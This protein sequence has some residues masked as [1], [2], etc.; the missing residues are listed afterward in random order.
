MVGVAG[1]EPTTCA[2]QTRRSTRLNYTPCDWRSRRDSNPEP[3]VSETSALFSCAT[4]PCW[5]DRG[6]SELLRASPPPP[7]GGASTISPR[8]RYWSG[9]LDLNQRSDVPN[10]CDVARLSYALMN[11]SGRRESDPSSSRWQRDTLPLSYG[12]MVSGARFERAHSMRTV[13][14]TAA[15]LPLRRRTNRMVG[16]GRGPSALSR[17]SPAS[18]V[19]GRHSRRSSARRRFH[20]GAGALENLSSWP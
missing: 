16:I 12:R 9:R 18:C 4:E 6:E 13:L 15:P 17:H 8:S 10:V 19:G 3:L 20:S 2:P 7:Q 14:Q 5:C 1:I 11:W